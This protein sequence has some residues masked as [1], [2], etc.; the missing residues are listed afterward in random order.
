MEKI[1][2]MLGIEDRAL[3]VTLASFQ[4]KGDADQW[5]K[6]EKGSVG[7][8]WEAFVNAFQVKFLSLAA[9]EKLREQFW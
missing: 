4:L 8:A 1:F 5:W 2:E 7:G 9:R 3:K 6:Y